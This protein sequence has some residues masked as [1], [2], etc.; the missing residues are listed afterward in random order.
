MQRVF[1]HFF[2]S[3]KL[4][5][6][7]NDI[8]RNLTQ[9]KEAPNSWC[10][11]PWS[12]ISIKGN[13]AYRLCC[14][15]NT[16]KNQGI[17]RDK[18][19]N[20]LHI[21]KTN[22]DEVINSDT[23]K[24]VRKNMLAGKWS[25]ECVRCQKE[26]NSGM[27]SRNIHE[28]SLLA[29]NIEPEHY[30]GYLKAKA[31]TQSDGTISVKDFPVSFLDIRFGNLCNLKCA[32]CSPT[33]SSAWY[34][35]HNA[36]WGRYFEDSGENVTLKR[37]LDGK[38]T[39]GKKDIFNWSDNYTLWSQLE[40]HIDQ[41]RRIH[42]VG[43]EPLLIKAY[44]KFLKKCI[45]SGIANKLIIEFNSNITHIPTQALKLWK[46]FK[47][48][49]I[50]ISLD[51]FGQVNDF[52]RY[53]S[54]WG[55]LEKNIQQLNQIEGNLICYITTSVSVLNIL[56]LPTF[57]EYIMKKNYKGI[58]LLHTP[59]I[60]PHPVYRPGF[61]NINILD[62][63]FK[64]KIGLHF[65]KYKEKISNYDWQS[66]Y[67]NSQIVSWEEKII[68][69]CEILDNYVKFMQQSSYEK[70]ELIKWRSLFIHFMDKLNEL[71]N[72]YWR[73]TFPELYE[74]TLEWRKLEQPERQEYV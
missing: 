65:D 43:G 50:G 19:G 59:L 74:S 2:S 4:E 56:H 47:R 26:F 32:M 54:R 73:E 72:L 23:M 5:S 39:I 53:P 70:E 42:I 33:D 68:R 37:N 51:G 36:I 52:I 69:A 66:I 13:G 12:H 60:N 18:E 35:E 17:L 11:L 57:I 15:S 49:H 45:E 8:Q 44:Y 24:S 34:K 63:A 55:Q 3:D 21:G 41:F 27:K 48:I 38:I 28:R 9:N 1:Q 30:P 71:R 20:M 64:E 40:K 10:P 46:Q 14:H 31:L 16:S 61:L 7:M 22:W 62:E 58:G 25:S 6:E 67:G 29:E